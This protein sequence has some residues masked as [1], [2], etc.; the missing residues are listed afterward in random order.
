ML[1]TGAQP[2]RPNAEVSRERLMIWIRVSLIDGSDELRSELMLQPAKRRV[3]RLLFLIYSA[4]Q[5]GGWPDCDMEVRESVEIDVEDAFMRFRLDDDCKEL[6][7][8]IRTTPRNMRSRRLMA[9]AGKGLQRLTGRADCAPVTAPPIPTPRLSRK[10]DA[11][12]AVRED[13]KG[14]SRSEA[15]A[16][17]TQRNAPT[18]DGFSDENDDALAF[19]LDAFLGVE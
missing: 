15:G 2:S 14:D 19:A 11:A 10:S 6:E 1:R 12:G 13:A 4:W 7:A 8:Y 16:N 9:L 3:R 5:P 17:R 18:V